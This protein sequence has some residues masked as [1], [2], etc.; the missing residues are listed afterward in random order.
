M[1]S[2]SII[3]LKRKLLQVQRISEIGEN[4]LSPKITF[5]LSGVKML[6][7]ALEKS[8]C[9]GLYRRPYL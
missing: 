2:Q 3:K 5:E 8:V 9:R 6:T 7:Q 4:V 1:I